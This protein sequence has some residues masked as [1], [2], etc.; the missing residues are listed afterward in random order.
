MIRILGQGRSGTVYL[1][2]HLELKEYRA[3]KQ[4]PKSCA[5][6]EQFKKE[7]LLLTS[8]SHPGIPLVY[9]LE[10]DGGYS[11]LI[12][13]YLE[14]DTL[15]SLV[16]NQGHLNQEAV[17]RIGIQVCDLVHYLHSA[18][19]TPILYLDLQ[20]KNLLFCHGHVKLL[21]FDQAEG[22]YEANQSRLR[23]GTPGFC[24][25]EQ[26][27]G[28]VLGIHTDIYQIGALLYYLSMGHVR[29]ETG[30]RPVGG[31]LGRMI[32]ICVRE[33]QTQRY[34]CIQ[35][36]KEELEAL[37]SQTG[38]VKTN[39]SSL[40]LAL[41]GSR[42]G[43][44]TTHLAIGLARYFNHLG[45][46]TLY[47]EWNDSGDVRAMAARGKSSMDSYG[48]YEIKRMAMKPRYGAA[49][50]LKSAEYPIVIRDYGT[51][52]SAVRESVGLTAVWLVHGGKWWEQEAGA[53]AV[54][55][56]KDGPEFA[57][58]YNRTMA[59]MR[60]DCPEGISLKRCFQVPE[61]TN[62]WEPGKECSPFFQKLAELLIKPERDAKQRTGPVAGMLRGWKGRIGKERSG[63]AAR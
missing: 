1:A 2:F 45:Y 21:D 53:E 10:E 48:I 55:A 63:K 3:V 59:G 29:D 6:Y 41:A 32:E 34:P 51:E 24:A 33:D 8:L 47:E 60:P 12:E 26:K 43:V 42:R 9:D 20:P 49:V 35:E 25:P 31:A 50:Y 57:V 46:R 36:L 7:A 4:V 22:L 39:Q 44:G 38:V 16:R 52:W 11:Y 54:C 28:G 62:P 18:G 17:I 27:N 61:F 23:Y 56:L 37:Y 14:G 40:T 30:S 15:F 19:K 58:L 5:D 13:E